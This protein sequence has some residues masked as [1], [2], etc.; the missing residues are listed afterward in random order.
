MA[1]GESWGRFCS[2][3]FPRGVVASPILLLLQGPLPGSLVLLFW[4]HSLQSLPTPH[5]IF[6]LTHSTM[7]VPCSPSRRFLCLLFSQTGSQFSICALWSYGASSLFGSLDP[8]VLYPRSRFALQFRTLCAVLVVVFLFLCLAFCLS[9]CLSVCVRLCIPVFFAHGQES[10]YLHV[11]LNGLN[12]HMCVYVHVLQ[13]SI[14][15][16]VLGI[17]VFTREYLRTR[18][19]LTWCDPCRRKCVAFRHCGG[20]DCGLHDS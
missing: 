17:C 11:L 13:I 7:L 9:V 8:C 5:T 3:A 19:N 20:H 14:L 6:S 10:L 4:G 1:L 15:R 2:T 16:Y 18:K 12:V